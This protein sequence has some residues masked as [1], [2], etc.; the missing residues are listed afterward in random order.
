MVASFLL[1]GFTVDRMAKLLRIDPQIVAAHYEEA[2]KEVRGELQVVPEGQLLMSQ[3]VIEGYARYQQFVL[4][5]VIRGCRKLS[6]KS[7]Y[8]EVPQL[9]RAGLET[10][11]S[12][13]EKMEKYG[14]LPSGESKRAGRETRGGIRISGNGKDDSR[15][16]DMEMDRIAKK[17][18]VNIDQL[19]KEIIEGSVQ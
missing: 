3:V 14:M 11:N 15:S 16:F 9:I 6:R 17:A 12:V 2:A 1:Q 8:R 13:T 19:E 4:S 7:A 18:G 10:L 5:T